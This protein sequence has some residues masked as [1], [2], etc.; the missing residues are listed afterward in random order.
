MVDFVFSS[1]K[2]YWAALKN[3][4]GNL[5]NNTKAGRAARKQFARIT[6]DKKYNEKEWQKNVKKGKVIS[7]KE[8]R[9]DFRKLKKDS[10]DKLKAEWREARKAGVTNVSW[11]KF[12]QINSQP[13][14]QELAEQYNSPE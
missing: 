11:K 2:Q 8:F 3:L 4:H 1:K 10:T 14:Y 7:L 6:G 13:D 9:S 12:Q 5:N